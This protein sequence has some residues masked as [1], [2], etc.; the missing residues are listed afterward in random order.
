MVMNQKQM[1]EW[2]QDLIQAL[3]MLIHVEHVDLSDTK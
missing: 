1:L 3:N 2:A